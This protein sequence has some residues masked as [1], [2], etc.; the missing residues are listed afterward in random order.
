MDGQFFVKGSLTITSDKMLF[1]TKIVDILISP[2]KIG[3]GTHLKCLDEALLMSTHNI[4]FCG[5]IRK[6]KNPDTPT[7]L[8]LWTLLATGSG[9]RHAVVNPLMLTGLF[10]HNFGLV[11][12]QS[13]GSWFTFRII[14]YYKNSY[15]NPL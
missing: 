8:E 11:H 13:K 7:Y 9:E 12:F 3:C 4:H 15:T 14:T 5:E 2:Q 6:E 10:Y 1:Q